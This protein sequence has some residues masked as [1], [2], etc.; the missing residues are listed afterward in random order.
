MSLGKQDRDAIELRRVE[1]TDRS[2]TRYEGH[3]GR[4]PTEAG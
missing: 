4:R 1:Q 3:H 2:R